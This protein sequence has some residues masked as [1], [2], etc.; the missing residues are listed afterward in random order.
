MKNIIIAFGILVTVACSHAF[1]SD[2]YRLDKKLSS[3]S[4]S[5]I[6]NQY[7]I[8]PASIQPAAG[9]LSEDGRLSLSLDITTIKTGVSIRDTRLSELYFES[10]LFPKVNIVANLDRAVFTTGAQHAIIPV[11]V[12]LYG[13]KKTLRFPV[14]IIPTEHYLIAST[15]SPVMISAK[16]FGIPS[17]NLATLAKLA[18]GITISDK[19][20]LNFNLVFIKK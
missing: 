7:V 17:E 12:E 1:A 10:A 6:K 5:T 16:D 2:E 19:T 15:S 3:I 9:V 14:T 8:E 13:V 20:P 11:D 4:F 18:G